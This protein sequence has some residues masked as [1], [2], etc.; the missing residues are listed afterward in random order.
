MFTRSIDNNTMFGM[1]LYS[2]KKKKFIKIIGK[3][4]AKHYQNVKPEL[5]ELA[6]NV[7]IYVNPIKDDRIKSKGFS[8]CITEVV[9]NPIL[10]FFN[11]CND[12]RVD[13]I[14]IKEGQKKYNLG[15]E[16]IQRVKFL[17]SMFN[18]EY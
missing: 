15:D 3:D 17:K 11:L 6:K 18:S 5:K 14:Y 7:D 1:A 13:E 4:Y 2:P 9:K 8:I 16:L 12:Y 10:R